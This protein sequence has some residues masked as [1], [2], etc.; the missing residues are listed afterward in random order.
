MRKVM[1]LTSILL[2]SAVGGCALDPPDELSREV[3]SYYAAHASEEDGACLSPQIASVKERSREGS[4][5]LVRYTYYEPGEDATEWP[6]VFH[7]PVDCT[8]EGERAFTVEDT[9]L[10]IEVIDMSGPRRDGSP[11]E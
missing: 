3:S 9:K 11:D 10:G 7:K 6:V 4:V 2:A 1:G 5:V 8:G